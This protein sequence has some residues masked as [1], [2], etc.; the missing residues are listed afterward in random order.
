M[1]KN[2]FTLISAAERYNQNRPD[3]HSAIIDHVKSH[4]AASI[5]FTSALDVGCGT[6]HSTYPLRRIARRVTG[7]DP[8]PAMLAQTNPEPEIQ[9]IEASAEALPFPEDQFDLITVGLAFHW[10]DQPAFLQEASRVMKASGRLVVYTNW[11]TGHMVHQP[12]FSPWVR[13]TY[14]K[15]F[16][17][18][19]RRSMM[20]ETEHTSP[21]EIVSSDRF[22]V[23]IPMR[24][25]Q[26][27]GYLTTQSNI[28]RHLIDETGS[29]EEVMGWLSD[30]LL[31]FFNDEERQL[32]FGCEMTY[33][34]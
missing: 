8:S 6:G 22:E 34:R 23:A 28:T 4:C 5:P 11:M 17:T 20:P 2:Y 19:A 1:I 7:I 33:Y 3:T 9:F 16:P 29:L 21:F 10:L 31:P 32:L 30:E 27:A 26:F 15:R 24:R 13:E 25:Q 14:L 12:A 18:P